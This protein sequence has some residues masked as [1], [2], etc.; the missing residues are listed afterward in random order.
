MNIARKRDRVFYYIYN[1]LLN[2]R[3][4]KFSIVGLSGVFVNMGA[5]YLLSDYFHI[6]Y[7]FSS[8]IAIEASIVSN[9]FLNALWT[10]SDREKKSFPQQFI[11]YHISVG[12]TAILINWL[13]LIFLTEILGIYYLIS[14]LIG[15][16]AGTLFNFIINDIWTFKKK[17]HL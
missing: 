1:N 9:F 14:N 16:G 5:L 4:L 10:W 8:I 2:K 17:N 6:Y 3:I 12:I 11:Q 15:I 7:I 13:I